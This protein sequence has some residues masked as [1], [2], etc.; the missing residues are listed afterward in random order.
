MLLSLYYTNVAAML[1]SLLQIFF[2]YGNEHLHS[3][4]KKQ[5]PETINVMGARDKKKVIPK[6][7]N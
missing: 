6:R 5:S 4:H 1:K 2:F 3:K 7:K